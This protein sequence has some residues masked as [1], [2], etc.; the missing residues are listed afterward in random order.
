M[1]TSAAIFFARPAGVLM[2]IVRRHTPGLRQ[3]RNVPAVDLTPSTG[4]ATRRVS[5]QIGAF[6]ECLADPID[7]S[8][9]QHDV[10]C[11]G[12]R[13]RRYRGALLVD[14]QPHFTL[15]CVVLAHPG[16]ERRLGAE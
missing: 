7:P 15:T 6:I 1:S 16:F 12:Y 9:A 8:P 3:P 10:E 5:L 13:D 4:R 14:A 11:F 2:L